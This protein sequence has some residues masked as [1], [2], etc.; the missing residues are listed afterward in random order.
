MRSDF[1]T[2]FILIDK[3]DLR[4]FKDSCG[5]ATSKES[6]WVPLDFLPMMKVILQELEESYYIPRVTDENSCSVLTKRIY[7]ESQ[8]FLKQ[9][10]L[11]NKI[12]DK[13]EDSFPLEYFWLCLWV[14]TYKII[15]FCDDFVN[16]CSV[17]EVVLIKRNKH[18]NQ[19]GLLINMTSFSNIVEAF[20]KSK[21][22]KV[23]ILEHQD[24]QTK[25]KTIF[26]DQTYS[27]KSLL[28]YLIRFACWKTLSFNKKNYDYILIN[29]AYDNI[30]N[31]Y[32]AI[33][34]SANKMSPQIFHG[35]Q[36]PF[37]H[38][39]GKWLRFL[40][41][42]VLFKYKYSDNNEHIIKSYRCNFYNFE[43]DFAE[44]FRG[45]IVQYLSDIRWM[46]NYINM[47]WNNCL[48]RGKRYLTIFSLPPVHLHSYFLI[49][50][51]KED[52]GKVAVWQHGGSYS[53]TEHFQHYI[54]DYKNADYFLAFGKCNIKE[55]TKS[56]GDTF[57]SC[58]QVGSN[59]IYAKSILIDS[60]DGKSWNSLGLYIPAVIGTLFSQA[61]IKWRG[62]LQFEAV[63]QIVDYFD[64]VA[65]GKVVVK[66]LENHKLHHELQKYIDI[67]KCKYISYADIPLDK[68]LSNNPKFVVLDDSSTPLL[69]VLA[70]YAGPIFLIVNQE[71]LS[72]REDALA[73]LKRR[74]VCSESVD[75][76]KMQL[77]D[78]FKTGALE[79]VDIEDTSFVD[80][81]L[82]RFSYYEYE[83]F[84][85]ETTQTYQL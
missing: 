16:Q 27:L 74:V 62:D 49:K 55:V 19:G 42:S 58:V 82:K 33:K 46:K 29:P 47:F 66:G 24:C 72:I 43:F 13:I 20:F 7:E 41:A 21:D 37:L 59:H 14:G 73:L 6:L 17:E 18:V 80:V 32:K 35:G 40:I 3:D 44:T 63:K 4:D 26:Y 53:Y 36:M 51:V 78:F 31:C 52:D 60:R 8:K 83:R 77:T 71:S 22:V 10:L 23:K 57:A 5:Y 61:S 67:K 45:T 11:A 54:T 34:C 84:I 12:V 1:K 85:K 39:W 81:Y 70:Q 38:S 68:A 75:E 69:Q 56:A 64:S 50:K 28:K 76:L 2:A 25:P 48:E 30:I 15:S 65:C 79:G 9:L